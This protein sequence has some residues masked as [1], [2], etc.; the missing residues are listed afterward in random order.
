MAQNKKN[1]SGETGNSSSTLFL[2]GEQPGSQQEKAGVL[3]GGTDT[4]RLLIIAVAAFIIG[5]GISFFVFGDRTDV[6]LNGATTTPDQTQDDNG[7]TTDNNTADTNQPNVSLVNRGISEG[8]IVV[9][10]QA[11]GGTVTVG[12]ATSEEIGW[13]VVYETRENGALGNILGAKLKPAGEW[14]GN[15][16]LLRPTVAGREYVVKIHGD[17]GDREFDH[18]V[19]LPIETPEG[20]EITASFTTFSGTPR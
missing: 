16:T 17:N 19:D 5:F 4:Q 10:E 8:D 7:T 15:V 14:S 6:D 20:T 9:S 12:N 13:V 11:P 18:E 2:S 1:E 3:R